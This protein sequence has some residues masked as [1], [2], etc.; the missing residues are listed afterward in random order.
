L[1]TGILFL[2]YVMSESGRNVG[3]SLLSASVVKHDFAIHLFFVKEEATVF[4]SMAY[5]ESTGVLSCL[6]F[7]FNVAVFK[8]TMRSSSCFRSCPFLP[9]CKKP[10]FY[11]EYCPLLKDNIH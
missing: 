6:E 7:G 4:V 10:C 2:S 5:P 9:V 3:W 1:G 11:P 8:Y